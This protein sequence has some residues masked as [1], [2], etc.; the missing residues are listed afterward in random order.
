MPDFGHT[1][2]KIAAWNLAG[3]G[4]IPEARLNRQ[5]EGLA[6]LDAEVIALVEVNPLSALETLR[7]GLADK[8]V[9]YGAAIVPQ[10]DDL[11]I[12][13]LYKEGITAENP[14]LLEGSD[15]G[16]SR[17]RKAFIVDLRVGRF[18]FML[19]VVHLKSGRSAASQKIRDDQAKTI[20][21]FIRE[22]RQASRDD[23]LLAGDFNMIPGQDVSNFHH[24]GGDDLMDFVSSWD[25][26]D[27]FSHILEAGRANLL[28]G[29][30]ISRTYSTEYIRGSLR[31]FPMHW[32][33][34]IGRERFRE[35]VSDHLPFVASFRIDRDRD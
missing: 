11:H 2:A 9:S 16:D 21:A 4:G 15:L 31:I 6:L 27:R 3:Y 17:R 5:V 32:C 13:V 22:R 8:G 10:A 29:F 34:D 23:I 19:V 7:Q 35:T 33:M 24:L 1:T 18:D 25:L 20:G 30:A 12:G 26:P 28:D 14:R